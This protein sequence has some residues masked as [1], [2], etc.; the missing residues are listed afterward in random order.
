[1]RDD[2]LL[3]TTVYRN[4]SHESSFLGLTVF[5]VPLIL[6]PGGLVLTLALFF[7][8]SSLWAL[9]ASASAA[10]FLVLWKWRHPAVSIHAVLQQL[11]LPRRLNHKERDREVLPSLSGGRR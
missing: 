3:T 9:A 7:P 2:D 8:V 11:T 6:G 4:L 1:M 5:D 10:L